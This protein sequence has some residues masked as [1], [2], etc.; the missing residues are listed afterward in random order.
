MDVV[1]H[2]LV[3]RGIY[4]PVS[5]YRRNPAEGVGHDPYAEMA[6]A[7]RRSRMTG[8]QA[9]FILDDQDRGRK[10]RL[11]AV[12]QAPFSRAVLNQGLGPSGGLAWVLPPSHSTCGTMKIIMAAVMPNTLNLTHAPS[13]KFFAT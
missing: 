7:S 5:R 3:D 8:V 4:H 2:Q 11:Q 12:P 13:V 1:L 9:A 10:T 6:V